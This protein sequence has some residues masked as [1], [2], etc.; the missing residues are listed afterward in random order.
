MTRRYG[1]LAG[2]AAVTFAAAC[3][4]RY[5]QTDRHIGT[6]PARGEIIYRNTPVPTSEG[7]L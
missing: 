1:F 6:R 5:R 7:I 3:W 2:L 4:W